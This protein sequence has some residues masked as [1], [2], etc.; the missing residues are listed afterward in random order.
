MR[1]GIVYYPKSG[2]RG[3]DIQSYA[4]SLLTEDAVLCDREQLNDIKIPTK[5]LCNGWF[6]ANGA[7]WPP[8]RTR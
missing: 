6:M 4:A 8:N 1:H 5:L 2:N 3:D 7:N